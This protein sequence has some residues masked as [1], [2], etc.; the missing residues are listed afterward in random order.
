V[1]QATERN[2]WCAEPAPALLRRGIEEFNRGRF[3]EQH[4]ILEELWRAERR[5]VRYLYQ[6]IL[7]I[8]VAFHHLRRSNYHGVVYMLTRGSQYLRPFAPVCQQVDVAGLLEAA[9]RAL[10]AVEA[11]G[12]GRLSDFDWRL[13]PHVELREA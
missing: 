9:A 1:T 4:E 13:V 2:G 5:D 7:Q 6:G 8:G 3:F 10:A 12:P 11:L